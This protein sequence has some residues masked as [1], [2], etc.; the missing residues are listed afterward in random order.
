MKMSNLVINATQHKATSDQLAAGVI[1]LSDD[2]RGKLCELLT[3]EEIPSQRD[4]NNRAIEICNLLDKGT[5]SSVHTAMI[6]GAP[7][8]M[9]T[10]E[11]TLLKWSYHPVYA[12]SKRESVEV[13]QA[14][15][16]VK[17]E[18]VFKHVGFVRV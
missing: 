2:A 18:N 9:A 14:D 12:F 1:D 8:F 15:G 16:S 17:K 11:K 3:F 13:Q 7:F 6:G 4:M 5:P 10:L